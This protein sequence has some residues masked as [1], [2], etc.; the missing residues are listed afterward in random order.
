MAIK[1]KISEDF[2]CE[3]ARRMLVQEYYPRLRSFMIGGKNWDYY[4]P[5]NARLALLHIHAQAAL[6]MAKFAGTDIVGDTRKTIK[7]TPGEWL[8]RYMTH[9]VHRN[10]NSAWRK[11]CKELDITPDEWRTDRPVYTPLEK[12]AEFRAALGP[13][14][15]QI[16][17]MEQETPYVDAYR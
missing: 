4:M 12:W 7:S 17:I 2:T 15:R 11:I 3:M 16:R 1:C 8:E 13:F 14:L 6:Q 9:G 5:M 10:D